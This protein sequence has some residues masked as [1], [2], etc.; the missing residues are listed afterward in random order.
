MIESIGLAQLIERAGNRVLN[1]DPDAVLRLD[2]L[3]GKVIEVTWSEDHHLYASFRKRK[4]TVVDEWDG[5]VDVTINGSIFALL[6]AFR[7][8]GPEMFSR[9]DIRIDGNVEILQQLG[10]VIGQLDIDWEEPI[11]RF[12]GDALARHVGNA[13]R[14]AASWARAA[15]TT[16]ERDVGEYLQEERRDLASRSGVERLMQDIETLRADVARIS[17]RVE[18]LRRRQ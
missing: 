4:F 12:I 6:G 16:L 7:E 5:D 8:T 15:S 3:H 11:A 13:V 10:A 9:G 17:K 1:L 2:T 18:R 14:S